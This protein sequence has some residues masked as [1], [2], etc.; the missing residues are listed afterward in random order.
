MKR[1][2]VVI[3][4]DDRKILDAY[5]LPG[6]VSNELQTRARIILLAGEGYNNAQI[7]AKLHVAELTVGLWVNRYL[8]RKPGA[9]IAGLLRDKTS[10]GK[11]RVYSDEARAWLRSFYAENPDTS[12]SAYTNAVH[13]HCAEAGFPELANIAR[14]SI[15]A[16]IRSD[17]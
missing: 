13:K 3:P 17:I 8:N 15:A 1:P 7:A 16:I 12:I 4:E 9:D 6:V 10:K 2:A 14:T 11:N 5:Q